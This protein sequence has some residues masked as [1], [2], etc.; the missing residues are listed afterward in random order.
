MLRHNCDRGCKVKTCNRAA[1]RHAHLMDRT[2]PT[3][4]SR[5]PDPVTSRDSRRCASTR[6]RTCPGLRGSVLETKP[7]PTHLKMN[8]TRLRRSC[9]TTSA[10]GTIRLCHGI[11][12]GGVRTR[13]ASPTLH[14]SRGAF[15]PSPP[16]RLRP[17]ASS[18]WQVSLSRL[19]GTGWLPIA[20]RSWPR[21]FSLTYSA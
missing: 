21:V 15:K 2:L 19:S 7:R 4:P 3:P 10:R 16:H 18:Q 20:S 12:S 9:T 14:C 1:L 8:P 11:P 17:S 6:K 13:P 5:R